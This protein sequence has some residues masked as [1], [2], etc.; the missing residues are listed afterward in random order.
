K[1]GKTAAED[2]M[3]QGV[4]SVGT[5]VGELGVS[6]VAS[7]GPDRPAQ[8]R[9]LG[10]NL[11]AQRLRRLSARTIALAGL[12]EGPP[13]AIAHTDLACD[14]LLTVRK[15]ERHLAGEALDNRTVEELIGK[16]WRKSDRTPAT[17]LDLVEYAF[18]ARTTSDDFLIRESRF[19]D[20]GSGVHY[21]EKQIL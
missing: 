5:L 10:E 20:L 6:G 4:Q 18:S 12:L 19:L 2:L 8:I 15:L 11:R 7:I 3:K 1:T 21:S 17:G 9:A 14:L 16:T 13:P